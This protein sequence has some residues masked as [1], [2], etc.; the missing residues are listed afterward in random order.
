MSTVSGKIL[1]KSPVEK[2]KRNMKASSTCFDSSRI[3]ACVEF[4]DKLHTYIQTYFRLPLPCFHFSARGRIGSKFEAASE[5]LNS[6]A[7]DGRTARQ[8]L[9]L[10]CELSCNSSTLRTSDV[11]FWQLY[12]VS[13]RVNP[14]SSCKI[15]RSIF[16]FLS[17]HAAPNPALPCLA[18]THR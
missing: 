1:V 5:G 11:L 4:G 8:R 7:V 12:E 10:L 13:G 14:A 3:V 17:G 16:R 6:T 15:S 9:A 2:R 18:S